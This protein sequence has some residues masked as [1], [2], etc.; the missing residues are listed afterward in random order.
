MTDTYT[1][2]AADEL[3][4]LEGVMHE[5]RSHLEL[6]LLALDAGMREIPGPLRSSPFA[7]LAQARSHLQFALSVYESAPEDVKYI[8]AAPLTGDTDG[9]MTEEEWEATELRIMDGKIPA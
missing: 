2:D 3:A 5:M 1:P 6:A 8:S 9:D 7:D 4:T